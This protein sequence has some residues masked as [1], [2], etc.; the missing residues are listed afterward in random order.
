MGIK[1]IY[2]KKNTLRKILSIYSFVFIGIICFLFLLLVIGF[3]YGVRHGLYTF[4]NHEEKQVE[5]LKEK[6][7]SSQNFNS[8]WVPDNIGY[9][10]LNNENEVINSNM[11]IEDQ[12]NALDYLDGKQIPFSKGYFSKVVYNNRVCVFKY[13]IG[14]LYSSDWANSHLPRVESLFIFIIALTLLIP[15]MWFAKS[16]TR[17]IYK[18][19]LPLQKALVSIG[20]GDLN[21]P[22]PSSLS[23]SEFRE[24][25]NLM[26]HMRVDL[27]ATLEELWN[28]EHKIREQTTQMLHDYRS[29]LTVARANAEF[30]KEDLSQLTLFLSDKDKEKMNENLLKY[31][32][33]IIFNLNRLEEVA[34]RL[35][36]QLS[37]ENNDQLVKEPLPL[38]SLNLKI[39]Q[40]GHIL[41]EQYGNEW[42]SQFQ[43]TDDYTTTEESA[44]HQA[45]T[46]IILNACEHGHSPQSIHLTFIVSNGKAEY[47]ITN[48]GSHFSDA[49]LVHATD[50]GFSEKK[51]YT[52]NIKG[53]GL[54]FTA[55]VIR[56][57]GGE[58][59]LSNT[60][61]GYACV[62][63][64]IPVVKK[65]KGFKS[66]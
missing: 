53:V 23:I 44:I 24:L 35:Q 38:D 33:S 49:A 21:I 66:Q 30:M 32:E 41:S 46:N 47:K 36:L 25:G 12:E 39:N 5:I 54:Y 31:T 11:K 42:K 40:E 3:H 7:I 4:A 37:N 26:D 59:Y 34:D 20:N 61:E 22:V 43:D 60:P 15:T 63:V 1:N 2:S 48:S 56:E 65:N 62:Q 45:L 58:L 13:R 52:Q 50:K 27:K 19:V 64:I 8:T 57:N 6:I 17:H 16:V 29:P 55:R 10:Q 28:S 51:N 14:V 9:I 18:D